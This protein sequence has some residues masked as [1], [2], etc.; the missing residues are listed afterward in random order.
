MADFWLS[1]KLDWLLVSLL[2]AA[3]ATIAHVSLRRQPDDQGLPRIAWLGVV[4]FIVAA[5]GIAELAQ[6]REVGHIRE[7]VHGLAPTYAAETER[8]GHARL[9]LE[10]VRESPEYEQIIAAQLRWLRANSSIA[11]IYTVRRLRDGR[12]I[13]IVD[14]ETDYDRDGRFAGPREARTEPGEI[15]DDADESILMAF[16]G[17]T[18]FDAEPYTDRWGTW[19][20]AYTPLRNADGVVEAVLGVDYDAAEMQ[21]QILWYRLSAVAFVVSIAVIYLTAACFVITHRNNTRKQL[22][23]ALHDRLT[24]LPNR[25]LVMDRVDRALQRLRRDS[26]R[27]FAVLFIDFDRFK[28]INDSLGHDCGDQLLIT[29]ADRLRRAL[30]G[31]DCVGLLQADNSESVAARLGGDEFVVLLEEVTSPRDAV[32]VAE[33]IQQLLSEPVTLRGRDV[34]IN[35]SIGI[36]VGHPGYDCATDVIR[37]ADL[38]MYRAKSQGRAGY[39]IFDQKMHDEAMGRLTAELDLNNAAVRNELLLHFQPIIDLHGGRV[40]GCEALLRWRH[41][42]DG[43]VSPDRFI[44][45]A[46]ETGMIVPIGRWAVREAC[47]AAAEWRRRDPASPLYVSVNLSRRQIESPGIVDDVRQALEESGLPPRLL[48]LEI[49]ES[50]MMHDSR[51][52]VGVM[53]SLRKLGV[54]LYLDDFGTGF[55]SLSCLQNFPLHTIKLDRS[56]VREAGDQTRGIAVIDAVIALAHRLQLK[57]VAEG[58]ETLDQ[59]RLLRSI[60]CDAGQGYLFSAPLAM[61]TFEAFV[62]S[63]SDRFAELSRAAA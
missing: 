34:R 42:T 49:T 52:S 16:N 14:S 3:G 55:S 10:N 45:L 57:V 6:L 47:R 62:L 17:Q 44:P 48:K 25:Q 11:D 37:D 38:A 9:Q 4:F 33:R 22:V 56:F 58:I 19:V 7:L 20:S 30:R 50:T 46:E 36:T 27:L 1:Y 18:V 40:L 32:V 53:Q 60:G 2:L 12:I 61:E 63:A 23:W 26:T 51:L 8:L 21:C 59:W 15:F 24:G 29:L 41:P 5:G 35:A 31:E 28:V 13:F 39:A 43:L 54:D